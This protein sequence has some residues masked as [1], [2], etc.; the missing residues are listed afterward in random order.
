L[1]ALAEIDFGGVTKRISMACVP[2]AQ[3]GDYVL[4]HA[5]VALTLIDSI[6]AEQTLRML[7]APGS[8]QR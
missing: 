4:V 5:G 8:Q 6:Q 3:L 2:E 1:L 7:Q